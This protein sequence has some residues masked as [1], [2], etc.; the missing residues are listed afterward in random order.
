MTPHLSKSVEIFGGSFF[1]AEY[2]FFRIA[3]N[4]RVVNIH[5]ITLKKHTMYDLMHGKNYATY[6]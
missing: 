3:Q 1:A 2:Y 5:F 4:I 6:V